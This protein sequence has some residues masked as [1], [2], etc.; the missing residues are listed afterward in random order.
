[1]TCKRLLCLLLAALL[2]LSFAPVASASSGVYFTMINSEEPADLETGTMPFVRNGT[3]YVPQSTL[4]QLEI[5][6]A[7]VSG[8]LH[9]VHA[10]DAE[11]YVIFDLESGENVT[12][13]GGP[14]PIAPLS[15]FGTF[16]FPVGNTASVAGPLASYF[17]INLQIIETEPA[18]TVRLYNGPLGRLSHN[19]IL[20]NGDLL[21]GLTERYAA[22]TGN[23]VGET[24][25]ATVVAPE[26]PN[27]PP[28]DTEN[29]PG[30]GGAP[31]T[32]TAPDQDGQTPPVLPSGPVSISFVGLSAQTDTLLDALRQA[33]ISAGFFVTAEDAL[34]HPDLVR[35]LHGEGHQLGIFLTETAE[36]EYRAASEALFE[37][38]RLRTVF[39]ATTSPGVAQA[40]EAM[41]LLVFDSDLRQMTGGAALESLTGDLLLDS[42]NG[43]AYALAALPEVLRNNA[44][45]VVSFV[46]SL[47]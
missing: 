8:A 7:H 4:E 39:V 14:L 40:A 27:A 35:R 46:R 23:A 30:T 6:F 9:L 42:A 20:R 12:G 31:D 26:T 29:G 3:I 28:S 13:D 10:W 32:G 22:F 18:P 44:L 2:V 45:R 25:S 24:G 19:V 15:R 17:G 33:R 47:F 34:A 16:F 43:N 1:M 21:F 5:I 11:V 37:V 41:G 38:A 36:Q